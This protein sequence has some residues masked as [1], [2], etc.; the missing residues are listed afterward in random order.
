MDKQEAKQLLDKE[1]K[2][3]IAEMENF[4]ESSGQLVDSVP[5]CVMQ[6][7]RD[8]C[9]VY[10]ENAIML[11]FPLDKVLMNRVC[12]A[13]IGDGWK[14]QHDYRTGFW[15]TPYMEF[16]TRDAKV[17]MRFVPYAEGATCEIKTIQREFVL[18]E[19]VCKTAEVAQ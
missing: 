7:I 16:V 15:D 14:I 4:R 18:N 5:D 8:I 1:A 19:V 6:Y 10:L 2:R 17:C 3:V 9:K 11:I 13:F 12:E